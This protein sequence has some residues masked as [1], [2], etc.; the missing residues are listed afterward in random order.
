LDI[1]TAI[2]SR[3]I[4]GTVLV[5]WLTPEGAQVQLPDY[6]RIGPLI[7]E[8][9]A[10]PDTNRAK[11][12]LARVEVLNGTAWPDWAVLVADRLLWEGFQV[13]QIGQADRTDYQQTLIVDQMATTKGSPISWLARVLRVAGT[14]IVPSDTSSEEADFRVIVGYDFQPCYKSYWFNAH[15]APSPV[16]TA[17]P[18]NGG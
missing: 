2:K 18:T 7:A 1:D 15:P 16:P 11:Q 12:G 14:N 3:F 5:P 6:A 10:P 17:P 8:A 4:D 13:V 9:L